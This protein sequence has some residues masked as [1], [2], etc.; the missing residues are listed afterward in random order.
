[1]SGSTFGEFFH[2]TQRREAD[3]VEIVSGVYEGITTGTPICLL[4]RNTDQRSGDYAELLDT[5]RPG[6]ADY[7]YLRTYSRRDPRGGGRAPALL[8]APMVVAARIAQ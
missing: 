4:I 5:F 8:T 6:H 1:M 3:A 7:A 2:V